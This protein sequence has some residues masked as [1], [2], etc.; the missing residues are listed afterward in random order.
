MILPRARTPGL[1]ILIAE[2]SLDC[3][4]SSAILLRHYGHEVEI[5]MDG[6]AALAAAAARPPDVLL[7]DIGLPRMDGFEVARRL[8]E[9]AGE[10]KPVVIAVTGFGGE[11]DRLHSA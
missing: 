9:Q 6:P 5:A 4:E 1:R 3:A 10:E 8:R 2:D 11:A 7:L